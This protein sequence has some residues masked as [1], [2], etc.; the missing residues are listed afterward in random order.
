MPGLL[1][2]EGDEIREAKRERR[3]RRSKG[4][5]GVKARERGARRRAWKGDPSPL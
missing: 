1:C 3:R 4:V 5:K 2:G